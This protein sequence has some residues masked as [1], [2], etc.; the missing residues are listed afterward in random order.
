MDRTVSDVFGDRTCYKFLSKP[1]DINLLKEIYDVAKLGPTSFNTCPLRIT[2]VQSLEEKE[3]LY[4]CLM[5]IN[6]PKTRS[7]PVAAIFANDMKF[8]DRIS[9]LMP[10]KPEVKDIFIASEKL[11]EDTAIRNATLQAAYFMLVARS[12]GL[13]CGPMSGFNAEAVNASFFANS[14]YKANFICNL[15]YRDGE[16]PFSRLPRLS[17]EQCCK[18]I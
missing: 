12:Y 13:A 17:F 16:N 8:Y 10:I 6:I 9:E 11:A 4:K 7:A 18:V 2:F 15:G 5:D 1:V 14:S 3:K